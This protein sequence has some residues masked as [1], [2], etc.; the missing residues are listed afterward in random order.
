VARNL[1]KKG[2]IGVRLQ[3]WLIGLQEDDMV[4]W[5]GGD[6]AQRYFVTVPSSWGARKTR[7]EG[8]PSSVWR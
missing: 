1:Y 6:K 5:Q 4:K 3:L 2:D 8:R 7:L